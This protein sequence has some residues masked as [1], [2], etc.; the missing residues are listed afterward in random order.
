M[1]I[2]SITTKGIY[3]LELNKTGENLGTCPDCSE[4]RKNQK[5]KC[6]SF[7][8][9]KGAGYCSHCESRFVEHKP[10]EGVEYVRPTYDD[11]FKNLKP[12]WIQNFLAKRSI[13]ESTLIKM[14]VSSKRVWMPQQS[15]ELDVVAYPYFR[16]GELINVKY[17][18]A[19]KSFKLES[20][21]ELCWYNY[22]ALVNF[23]DIIC[24][25]GENDAL[26][27]IEAGLD[28]VISVPN[29]A[30]IGKMEYFDNSI[31]DLDKIE[32]F[33]ICTDNDEKG[34]IL[35]DELIRRLGEERCFICNLRQYK[36]ANEYLV[37]QGRESLA[38]VLESA[39]NPK[40]DGVFDVEDFRK[41]TDMLYEHGMKPGR[42]IGYQFLDSLITWETKRLAVWSGT[43][44][45]GKSEFIDF[46]N[47][48]LNIMNGW[49][50]AYYSPE[51]FPV[52][53][54]ISKL[55]EKVIGLKFSSHTMTY[56]QYQMALEYVKT[57]YFWVNPEDDSKIDTILAKFKFLIK[58]KGI[59]IVS[60]DPWNTID[61]SN[62][63]SDQGQILQKIVK[64]ARANDVL[65][66][67][68]AHP[69]KLQKNPDGTY[70]TPNM[71]DIAGSS[72][73]WNMCDYGLLLKRNQ[74]VE[75]KVFLNEGEI[76]IAKVKFKNLGTQGISQWKYNIYNGR[77]E[78]QFGTFENNS[79][80][81]SVNIEE[82]MPIPMNN[83][84][85]K[86][87]EVPF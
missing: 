11:S 23:K 56:E 78:S 16:N 28:N 40:I 31:A 62:V 70:P 54:H 53:N 87:I 1:K 9:T 69:K 83:D 12:E 72:D 80:L 71:Y 10:F 64:F 63:F 77:Y 44:S 66:H 34:I 76:T 32:R 35:R 2:Y 27:W 24:V 14:K 85:F 49:K 39:K 57:N 19:N 41:E 30:S 29:G 38:T 18:G 21:A 5:A 58:T 13:S 68:A 42:C 20:G 48:R 60:V 3:D 52:Q 81:S 84:I 74:D 82:S 73:F 75:T 55:V 50:V 7:N 26:S 67:L 59:K 22:D 47:I 6:F 86:N 37:G 61:G 25:E 45:S 8:V 51:N 33:Y 36:D 46:V 4:H 79:W 65:F 43:P 17:R 15:K